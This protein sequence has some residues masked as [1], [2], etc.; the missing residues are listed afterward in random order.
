MCG[1]RLPCQPGSSIARSGGAETCWIRDHGDDRERQAA[2][3]C[4]RAVASARSALPP[5]SPWTTSRSAT[6]PAGAHVLHRRDLG[7]AAR[8]D[9]GEVEAHR[10]R[11]RVV[12]RAATSR[13]PR[14]RASPRA[15]RKAAVG[16]SKQTV[17]RTAAH[18]RRRCWRARARRQAQRSL[19]EVP[20]P[21]RSAADSGL[22]LRDR[23][24]I[25]ASRGSPA[26]TRTSRATSPAAAANEYKDRAEST[27]RGRAAAR[28]SGAL[29]RELASAA[30]EGR[31]DGPTETTPKPRGSGT[32]GRQ[33]AA[34]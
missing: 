14:W 3:D 12:A 26:P 1:L 32:R 29:R 19:R 25:A 7:R 9:E 4:L 6:R 28:P 13:P 18:R 16:A 34:T 27:V 31:D 5:R 22:S 21:K 11:N 8:R 30:P 33:W 24:P 2:D 10:L 23:S 15:E 20:G 17:R